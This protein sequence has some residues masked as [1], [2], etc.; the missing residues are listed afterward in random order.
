MTITP[1]WL[2]CVAPDI[3]DAQQASALLGHWLIRVLVNVAQDIS[4]ALAPGARTTTTQ[5][6]QRHKALRA[7]IPFDGQFLAN[8]LN[9]DRSHMRI[10]TNLNAERPLIFAG[11][12]RFDGY[13]AES[14][15]RQMRLLILIRCEGSQQ[16]LGMQQQKQ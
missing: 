10:L 7:I 8:L 15:G 11:V 2:N 6:L 12:F 16:S 3:S 13:C 1:D 4:L 5:R 9:I 14:F